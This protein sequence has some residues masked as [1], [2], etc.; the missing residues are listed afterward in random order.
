MMMSFLKCFLFTV[1]SS[2]ALLSSFTAACFIVKTCFSTN[3][4]LLIA[5]KMNESEGEIVDKSSAVYYLLTLG[6]FRLVY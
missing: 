1:S 6:L 4:I 2:Y 5:L 3:Q